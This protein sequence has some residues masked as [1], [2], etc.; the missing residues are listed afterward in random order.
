VG[1]CSPR[2]VKFEGQLSRYRTFKIKGVG[3]KRE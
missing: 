3:A 1:I 2:A